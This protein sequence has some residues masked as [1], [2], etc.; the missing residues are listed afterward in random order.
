MDGHPLGVSGRLTLRIRGAVATD[1]QDA[2]I[3]FR[4]PPFELV[5]RLELLQRRLGLLERQ[6]RSSP[7]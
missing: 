1:L 7:R 5:G 6:C 2:H 3:G 4:G